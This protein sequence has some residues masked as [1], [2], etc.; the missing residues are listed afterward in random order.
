MVPPAAL[1]PAPA[2]AL[3]QAQIPAEPAPDQPVEP[4]NDDLSSKTAEPD[5]DWAPTEDPNATIVPGQM[6]SDREEIPAPFTKEDADKAETMEARQRMSRAVQ[7]CQ[8]YWPSPHAVCGV[9]RDKYNSLGGPA[10]FLSFPNSPEYTNPDGHGKRTQ[11]LNGPIYWSA[12]TGAHPVVNSFVTKWGSLGWES[13]FLGYPTTDEIP[14]ADGVGR[15]QEFQGGAIYVSF[16]NALGSAIAGSIRAKW[17]TAGA[18]TPGSLLGYPLTDE[19]V[20]PDGGRRQGFE[21]GVM[22]WSPATGAFP[23]TGVISFI[24]A[25]K[26]V[27]TG[28]YGYPVGDLVVQP[29]STFQQFQGG[30]IRFWNE[31]VEVGGQYGQPYA[32]CRFDTEY[33]HRSEHQKW[34]VNVI[35]KGYCTDPKK[36]IAATT[37]LN[38]PWVCAKYVV[39]SCQGTRWVE[40]A[41]KGDGVNSTLLGRKDELRFSTSLPCVDGEFYAFTEWEI[42]NDNGGVMEFG[43][44][45][46]GTKL[47]PAP[48]R[49]CE[50]EPES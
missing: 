16:Q 28:Q 40:S 44:L 27:E 47:I 19:L 38:G 39:M 33:P 35:T 7:S 12:A 13:G 2:P 48:G 25:S 3:A 9:I 1:S 29:E 11:F 42:T 43:P 45:Y 4:E 32:D 23:V 20:N 14:H 46:T 50:S 10:S 26:G 34:R 31:T 17:N 30:E 15:R 8:Y 36:K 5:P 21:R 22:Y 41:S 49:P 18:E 37:T 24:W 6:R